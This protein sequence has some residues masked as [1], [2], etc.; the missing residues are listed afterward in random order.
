M[1]PSGSPFGGASTV[2]LLFIV[3]IAVWPFI[4][5]GGFAL[6]V[7]STA[8]LYAMVAMGL[9]LLL[10]QAGQISLGQAAFFGIGAFTAAVLS[11]SFGLPPLVGVIAGT[12]LASVVALLIGRPI[13]K[14][15]GYFLALAT[16]GLGEIFV[17][18][19]RQHKHWFNGQVGVVSL[20]DFSIGGWNF[21]SYRSQYYLVWVVALVT[22]LLTERALRSRV[23]R[24]LRA[25]SSSE[26]A[27]FTLGVRTASWK[28]RT[29][30]ISAF[31]AGLAGGLY[32]FLIGAV[33]YGSF[34]GQLSLLVMIMVL[35]GG[36]GSQWGAVIGAIL[37][38]WLNYAFTG[39]ATYQTALYALV[40]LL[41]LVFFPFGLM[42]IDRRYLDAVFRPIERVVALF[43]GWLPYIGARLAAAR[44]T[45]TVEAIAAVLSVDTAIARWTTI[46]VGRSAPNLG[47]PATPCDAPTA[48]PGERFLLLDDVTVQFGG[49]MAVNHVS[50][51]IS[52]GSISALLGPNGAGKTTLFNVISALQ[53]PSGGHV[54]FRGNAIDKMHP[55]EVARLGLARTFQSMRLFAN[56]SVLENVMVG[57]HRHEKAGFVAAALGVHKKEEAESRRRSLDALAVVG[58]EHLADW[59]VTALPYG[60][61]RLVEIARALAT[62][63]RLLLL[64]EP[65]AGMN[66]TEKKQLV[67]RIAA[68][69]EAGVT[70]LLVEHDLS[71]VM[72]VSDAVNVLN[73]GSLIASGTP[74][75]V[76]ADPAV[77]EAYLGVKHGEEYG[78]LDAE[79]VEA[80]HEAQA[81]H[82][83][84]GVPVLDVRGISTKYGS[85]SAIR[86]ISLGVYSG[87]IVAV[88]GSNGA[89][90]TTMLRTI[91]GLLRPY[92]GT[93]MY[94]GEDTT[95]LRAQ[96]IANK[97]IGHVPEGRHVFPTLS[98]IDNLKLGTCCR[99]EKG[100][101]AEDLDWVFEVFPGLADRRRQSA[102]TLSGGEQQMLAIGRGLM[103]RPK[104]MILDEPSMGLAPMLVEAIFEAL[105]KLNTNGLTLLVVEQNAKLMLSIAH[106]AFVL[107]TGRVALS[108]TAAELVCDERVKALYLGHSNAECVEG[109]TN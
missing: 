64:D 58:L 89:G 29:F 91:S 72:A 108:G 70:V 40:L 77:I 8:G 81:R 60:Q 76:Q 35:V 73:F 99:T 109:V 88:L 62:E 74:A 86:D 59:P 82:K 42:G 19:A 92:A 47:D 107:Q 15:K 56:M 57:R 83:T 39:F 101:I 90:K 106:H 33:Q 50:L 18:I 53:K 4:F 104:L 30:V 12:A 63:P 2:R 9:G 36:V 16:L 32:A 78:T 68:I 54:F 84:D 21:A 44:E 49:V 55:A 97:G 31:M 94:E 61:Q 51:S 41:L 46:P 27:A 105:V 102:G 17:V 93:V 3:A 75:E 20:P 43:F 11:K 65:A 28:L 24:A 96:E 66:A 100:Q 23:G 37:M 25:L 14:L 87:E 79:T 34:T 48:G 69:R 80:A 45:G 10:G 103:G 26:T 38:S 22:L 52:E 13:L 95:R 6:T 5:G 67:E 71:M 98:V 85:V 7:M 1:K